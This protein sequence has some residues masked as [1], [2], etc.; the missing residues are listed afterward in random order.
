[1]ATSN[2]RG[3]ARYA[4]MMRIGVDLGGTKIEAIALDAAGRELARERV[5]TPAHDYR[6]T[7][8]AIATLVKKIEHEAG[9]AATVGVGVPGAISPRT[10]VIKNANSVCLIGQPLDRDLAAA[11]GRPVRLA[12][13]A[14]CF[15]LSEAT[16]GAAQGASV[17]FGVILGTGV[18]GAIVID[19]QLVAGCNA[20][21]GEWGHNPLPWPDDQ[22]RPGPACYC[23]QRGCIETFLSGPG[24]ERDF[25][26]TTGHQRS[27]REIAHQ[28]EKGEEQA[29]AVLARYENRLARGLASIINVLDPDVIVLGGG[30]SKIDRLYTRVPQIWTKYIFSDTVATRLLKAEHGDSSGVRGAARLWPPD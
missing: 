23:G 21:T 7:V 5:A 17:V 15:A 11:L 12:N 29:D 3:D 13:D 24:L 22:E 26:A 28:A 6:A 4:G 9:G 1:M 16:D 8:Q 20:I 18:G 30:V 10:G 2:P 25:E 27:A 14:N 19:G